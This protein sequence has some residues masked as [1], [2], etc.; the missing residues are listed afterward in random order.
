MASPQTE[1]GYTQ[2][3]N[4]ILEALA[5]APIPSL[6]R[7]LLD[8]I[9]RQTYGFHRKETAITD[10]KFSKMTHLPDDV[11]VE[12]LNALINRKIIKYQKIDDKE[13]YGFNK[14]YDEWQFPEEEEFDTNTK[15]N[16]FD[17]GDEARN[18]FKFR[19]FMKLFPPEKRNDNK[20]VTFALF[21]YVLGKENLH[22][23]AFIESVAKDLDDCREKCGPEQVGS[24][25][26]IDYLYARITGHWEADSHV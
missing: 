10:Q 26:P 18:Q 2:I 21:F 24:M 17:I 12:Q 5:R 7:R 22:P 19:E 14:D 23:D 1:K 13:I 3:A 6:P 8:V 25:G 9:L 20:P 11:I 15:E 16:G 4:E